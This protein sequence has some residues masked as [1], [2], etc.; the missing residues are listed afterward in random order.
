MESYGFVKRGGIQILGEGIC[1]SPVVEKDFRHF[2]VPSAIDPGVFPHAAP[3]FDILVSAEDVVAKAT[4][5]VR[6]D[7]RQRLPGK[8][9]SRSAQAIILVVFQIQFSQFLLA[10]SARLTDVPRF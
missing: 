7:T 8:D 9:H 5:D 3:D 1:I 6:S 2:I 10:S 4:S